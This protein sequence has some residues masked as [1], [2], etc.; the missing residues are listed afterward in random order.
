MDPL[1]ANR[2]SQDPRFV[3]LQKKRDRFAWTLAAIV[4]VVYYG[5]ILVV[6]FAPD[7]LATN[8]GGVVTLGF[9]VG[10]G[11]IV[12]A[13]ILTGV[14]VARANSEFDHLTS[15]IVADVEAHSR[16]TYSGAAPRAMGATR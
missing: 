14:Y 8:I 5:F 12:L 1:M 11:V 4:L 10:L 7:V 15:Q 9:P 6:A 16:A 3:T 13:I 2:I